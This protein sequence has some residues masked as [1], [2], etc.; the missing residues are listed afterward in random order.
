MLQAALL[1]T[2]SQ[3]NDVMQRM[4]YAGI[5]AGF[6]ERTYGKE[7]LRQA[8]VGATTASQASSRQAC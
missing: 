7:L 4:V 3:E 2:D 6:C 5:V 1:R 8:F